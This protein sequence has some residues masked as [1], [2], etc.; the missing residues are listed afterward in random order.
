MTFSPSHHQMLENIFLHN[1]SHWHLILKIISQYLYI[2]YLIWFS[3]K[4]VEKRVQ[5][6]SCLW[7][8]RNEAQEVTCPVTPSSWV[9]EQD[10]L[11]PPSR[12]PLNPST[13]AP[14]SFSEH[15]CPLSKQD[16]RRS[17]VMR[18]G[19]TCQ[20]HLEGLKNNFRH[21]KIF[22]EWMAFG[23]FLHLEALVSSVAHTPPI[24][25]PIPG[26]ILG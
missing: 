11:F 5:G 20:E 24:S 23:F 17:A 12:P 18:K 8:I 13:V 21:V 15:E 3:H 6:F 22:G 19:P 25:S 2:C 9:A 1:F 14:V 4:P 10:F 7:G 16:I 26:H